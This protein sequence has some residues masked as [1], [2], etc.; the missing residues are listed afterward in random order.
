MAFVIRI[1]KHGATNAGS[2]TVVCSLTSPEVAA[3]VSNVRI[4]NNSGGSGIVNLFFKPSGGTQ[5]RI[6]TRDFSL[7]MNEILVVKPELTMALGD[8][9]EVTTSAVMDYI[10]CGMVQK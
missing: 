4:V 9:I 10:T 2:G 8:T 7:P 6:Y 5:H 3:I 1:L